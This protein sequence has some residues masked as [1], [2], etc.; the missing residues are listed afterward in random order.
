MGL[1]EQ[2]RQSKGKTPEDPE[3][4]HFSQTSLLSHMEANVHKLLG[5]LNQGLEGL[6]SLKEE[7][8]TWGTE[9]WGDGAQD[10]GKR[11]DRRRK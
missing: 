11:N 2:I 6:A 1:G 3:W 10:W 9:G 7:Q 5:I 4:D 8:K